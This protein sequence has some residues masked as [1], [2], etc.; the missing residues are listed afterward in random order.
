MLRGV[1][2]ERIMRS[3]LQVTGMSIFCARNNFL[4]EAYS[5]KQPP[6]DIISDLLQQ[7]VQIEHLDISYNFVSVKSMFCIANG[8]RFNKSLKFI[9]VEGNPLGAAGVRMLI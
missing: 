7:S 4:G 3:L 2:G 6:I 9:E 1:H 8:I 5:D